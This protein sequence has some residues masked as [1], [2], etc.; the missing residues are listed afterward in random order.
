MPMFG[1]TTA[2]LSIMES[3]ISIEGDFFS[4]AMTIPFEAVE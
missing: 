3:S 4:V 2:T 1:Q